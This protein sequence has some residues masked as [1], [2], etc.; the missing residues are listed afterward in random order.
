MKT[1]IELVANERKE[2]IEKHGHRVIDDVAFNST[3]VKP[4]N[5]LPLRVAV[6][7]LMGIVGGIPYPEHWNKEAIEKLE[8]KTE[9]E[10]LITAGAFICAEID[11]LIA[12]QEQ[13]IEQ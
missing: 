5:M 11:R 10:K 2:Q 12:L 3:R 7:N 1:A 6:G 13:P 8:S 9:L 4:F